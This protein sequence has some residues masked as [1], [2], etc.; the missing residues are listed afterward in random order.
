MSLDG[1]D[2]AVGAEEVSLDAMERK[3]ERTDMEG[4]DLPLSLLFLQFA[5][6]PPSISPPRCNAA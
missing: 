4:L 2:L 5:V 1:S 3:G 6:S